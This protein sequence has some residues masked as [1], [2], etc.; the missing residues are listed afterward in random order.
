MVERLFAPFYPALSG[1]VGAQKFLLRIIARFHPV[2]QLPRKHRHPSQR[3]QGHEKS[4]KLAR[5]VSYRQN[6][7]E[8]SHPQPTIQRGELTAIRRLRRNTRRP[9]L[10]RFV[11]QH[12]S[13]LPRFLMG[14][15]HLSVIERRRLECASRN[16]A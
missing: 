7:D 6:T 4:N 9:S 1:S 15:R 12:A 2:R 10:Y 3:R 11:E 16:V 13:V 5:G 14:C 8:Q